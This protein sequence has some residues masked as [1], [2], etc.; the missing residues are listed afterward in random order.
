MQA[1]IAIVVIIAAIWIALLALAWVLAVLGFI[2]TNIFVA[3]DKILGSLQ[4]VPPFASWAIMGFILGSLLYFAVREAPKLNRPAVQTFLIFMGSLLI[5]TPLLWKPVTPMNKWAKEEI[6]K[7]KGELEEK[8]TRERESKIAEEARIKEIT[9]KFLGEWSGGIGNK[10]AKLFINREGSM[11]SGKIVFDGVEEKLA[12]EV[13]SDRQI[14]LKGVSYQRLRGKG[15]FNLDTFYGNLPYDGSSISGRY[16]DTAGHKGEW[17]VSRRKEPSVDI[18]GEWEGKFVYKVFNTL[19]KEVDFKIMFK[20]NS[21]NF[22]GTITYF[23]GPVIREIHGDI[24]GDQISFE[25][26][27]KEKGIIE[28]TGIVNIDNEIRGA[29]TNG[30]ITGEWRLNRISKNTAQ[31]NNNDGNLA[32]ELAGTFSEEKRRKESKLSETPTATSS[33]KSTSAPSGYDM[34][35][36]RW[37]PTPAP[38]PNSPKSTYQREQSSFI[39]TINSSPTGAVVY[40]DKKQVGETPLSLTLTKGYHGIRLEKDGYRTKWEIIELKRDSV[41]GFNFILEQQ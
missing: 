14:I 30:E 13:K 23:D 11:L 21:N 17:S 5:F 10:K 25:Y 26:E 3:G 33:K 28:Y 24:D 16:E 18:S 20:Q 35:D 22:T 38:D 37:V 1:L 19:P 36:G 40:I 39:V 34:K 27:T 29:W 9:N 7:E 31:S 8:L 6:S 12:V 4:F 2:F 41:K 32:G 15:D